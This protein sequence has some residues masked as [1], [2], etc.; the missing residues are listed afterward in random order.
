MTTKQLANKKW[1]Q[2]NKERVRARYLANREDILKRQRERYHQLTP[3]EKTALY[4]KRIE[5]ELCNTQKRTH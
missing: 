2:A 1:Y 4:V 3:E 5:R